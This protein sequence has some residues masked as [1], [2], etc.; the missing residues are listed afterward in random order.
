MTGQGPSAKVR[1]LSARSNTRGDWTVKFLSRFF[2]DEAGA[3]AIEYALI[4]SL[5]A[6][7]IITGVTL[8]GTKLSTVYT[9]IGN[10]LN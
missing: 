10:S 7:V 1:G 5:I 8:V 2:K 4:A 6:I 9:E 3:T